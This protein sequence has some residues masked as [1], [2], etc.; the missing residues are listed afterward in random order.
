MKTN[1]LPM[2][3]ESFYHVY[4]R[5]VN[6]ENIFKEYK[7][8]AYFL[9]KYAQFVSPVAE[10]YAYCLLGNH[11]HLLIRTY[12]DTQIRSNLINASTTKIPPNLDKYETHWLISNAFA[13][14]FKGYAQTINKTYKRTGALFEEPF[15]RILVDT[16]DY[17]SELIY[18]IHHNPQKHGFVENFKTYEHSSYAAHLSE[19]P[20]KLN[21]DAVL[22]WFGG[23]KAFEHFHTRTPVLK[24]IAKYDIEEG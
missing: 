4:N 5:G 6:G 11:F 1:T 15:R 20:T 23:L 16:E 24:H 9:S 22:G 7:N 13:S 8:Y 3:A 17:F 2:A 18:Y 12:S 14:L 21:R 19:N 10:T